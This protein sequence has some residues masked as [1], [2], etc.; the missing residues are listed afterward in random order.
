MVPG[1]LLL[2]FR[3]PLGAQLARFWPDGELVGSERLAI[4]GVSSIFA[5]GIALLAGL[6]WMNW[7]P[8]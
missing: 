1:F 8:L 7:W 2:L 5:G 4:L 6:H 3:R